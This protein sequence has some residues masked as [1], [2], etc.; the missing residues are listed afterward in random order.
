MRDRVSERERYR[1]SALY[2]QNVTG[3]VEKA[4]EAYELWAK[5]YPRDEIPRGSLGFLYSALGQYEKAIAETEAQ[6]R[7]EP[8][9]AGYANLAGI[10]INVN[11]LKDAR[12]TLEEAQ[13]KNFDGLFG[14]VFL[15]ISVR[16]YGGNGAPG[17]M[18]G[19]PPRRGRPDAQ[20]PR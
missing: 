7:L 5:S 3:E 4:T 14:S 17:C 12:Q 20:H 19:W 9:I 13:Q 1:I 18:D 8:T 6:Q 16:G 2:F 10:Y 15:G 11:R